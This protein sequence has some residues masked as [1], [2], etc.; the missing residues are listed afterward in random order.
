MHL[1]KQPAR[2]DSRLD[3]NHARKVEMWGGRKKHGIEP[4]LLIARC[5][6]S[7]ISHQ[8]IHVK[9]LMA[10]FSGIQSDPVTKYL[11]QVGLQGTFIGVV[12]NH[13]RGPPPLLVK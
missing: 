4:T 7:I 13:E 1:E 9:S 8:A 12:V 2:L 5:V 11:V 3:R 6:L 10:R